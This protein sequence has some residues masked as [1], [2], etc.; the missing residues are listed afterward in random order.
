MK[1]PAALLSQCGAARPDER[2][3]ESEAARDGGLAREVPPVQ[4]IVQEADALGPFDGR[5]RIIDAAIDGIVAL[6]ADLPGHS[7][8]ETALGGADNV[9]AGDGEDEGAGAEGDLDVAGLAAAMAV[10]RRL[11]VDDR[12]RERHAVDG[13]EIADGRADLGK[14]SIGTPKRSAELARP[15]R[16]SPRF[17]SE[18]RLAVVT[19]VA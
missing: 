7:G 8:K 16:R 6:R 19:S 2:R 1:R 18:V 4:Q 10:E 5:A 15:R 14:V 11:L 12:G 13:A 9:A 17:M 3:D